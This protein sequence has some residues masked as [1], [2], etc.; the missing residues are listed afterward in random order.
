MERE[1]FVLLLSVMQ[2]LRDGSF[3]PRKSRYCDRDIVLTWL[4]AVLHDRPVS[5]ACQRRNWP[6][7]DRTRAL[8]SDAT[9]SR[10]LRT[11]SVKSLSSRVLAS[12]A[13]LASIDPGLLIIDAKP[14]PV[15]GVTA[16][17]DSRF[18]HANGGV[19]CNGYKLHSITDWAGNQVVHEVH[20]MNV[21]EAVVAP[22]LLERLPRRAGEVLLGDGSYDAGHLYELAAA[23]GLQLVAANR[24]PGAIGLG[25][26][27]ISP[28]RLRA[29]RLREDYPRLLRCRRRIETHFATLGNTTGGLSPLPNHVRR[30][31]RV[32]RWVLGKLIID[33]LHR[34]RRAQQKAS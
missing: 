27:P 17:P 9:M 26:R 4:W 30:L 24:R 19:M 20:P 32:R 18:G 16:D 34:R 11:D 6:W 28:A 22:R 33:A 21:H 1:L 15:S 2:T 12:L 10:R 23:G 29:I 25:H 13:T 3:R 7:H 14:V 5:W 8:P 31:E